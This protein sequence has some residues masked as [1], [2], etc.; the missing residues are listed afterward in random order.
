[1][2]RSYAAGFLTALLVCAL[3]GTAGASTGKVTQELEYRNIQVSLDGKILDL[4][5]AAGEKVE[6]FMFGG[7]N[8]L[9]VRAL[10]EALGLSVAWDGANATV[11][12][13]SPPPAAPEETAVLQ[14]VDP[15]EP[16]VDPVATSET[17]AGQQDSMSMFMTEEKA[18]KISLE[19]AGLTENAVT[20]L[21]VKLESSGAGEYEVEFNSA[22]AEYEYH[23]DAL[24]GEIISFEKDSR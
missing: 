18:K 9:P 5:N 1:M 7:T 15:A 19:H 4:R 21:R 24:S 8:Y 17:A 3:I 10:A 16:A 2:K 11:V 12:L 6:P 14:G 13:T 22:G 23:I 20:G